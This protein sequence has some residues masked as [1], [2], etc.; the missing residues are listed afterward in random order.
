MKMTTS[1]F[2]FT[3]LAHLGPTVISIKMYSYWLEALKVRMIAHRGKT[4]QT[5]DGS[6]F[7]NFC[8]FLQLVGMLYSICSL[9][10]SLIKMSQTNFCTNSTELWVPRDTFS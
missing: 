3:A 10:F 2:R 7:F 4:P 9:T 8:A 1:L 6:T 5:T